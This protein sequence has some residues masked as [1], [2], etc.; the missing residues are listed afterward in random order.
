M[1]KHPDYI[2]WLP[3]WYPTE[4]TPSN[5]DF[6]QRHALA[7]SLYT[8]IIILFV[9]KDDRLKIGQSKFEM[10][11]EGNKIS[12]IG[13]YG[14]TGRTDII[15][16]LLSFWQYRKL[17]K[18]LFSIITEKYGLPQILHVHIAMNAGLLALYV[19]KN[20]KIP[21][22][23]TEN[24]TGYYAQSTPN[25]YPENWLLNKLRKK[26][27]KEADLF[28]PV[29][30]NLGEIINANFV[31][32]KYQVIP[33]V[34]NTDLFF[35]KPV[36]IPVFRFVHAS[37]LN[38]QKNPEGMI[39]AAIA[40]ARINYTFELHLIGRMDLALQK[41]CKIAN[42]LDKQVFFHDAVSYEQIAIAMQQS[43][44]FLLFSRFE[45]LPCVILE[46]LCCGLPVISSNVG[47]IVEVIDES[48]GIIVESEN[49]NALIN[50]MKCMM[51]DYT[52]Y[53]R[54]SIAISAANLFNYQKVGGMYNA[55]YKGIIS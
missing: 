18:K 41:K 21:Y 28:L 17:Q 38:Y 6:I 19:K 20:Y 5:G 3:S 35:Y 16:K 50:A 32:V 39:D 27:F 9:Q 43:S 40:L 46:A 22:F 25:I 49:N 48:N 14:T 13:Y 11:D 15:E 55:L 2:L 33:N 23:I 34:V 53:N 1:K 8:R 45:N 24:W 31:Q 26:I 37:Y 4:I 44:A 30:K 29:T 47:G 52:K 7:V 36:E 10:I 12:I 42:V 54:E 51:D